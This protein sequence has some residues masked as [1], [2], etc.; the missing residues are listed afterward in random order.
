M[1]KNNIYIKN[2]KAY[3]NFEILDTLSAGIVLQGTEVKSVKKSNLSFNDAYCYFK[4]EE[5]FIKNLHISQYEFG[6]SHDPIRD[7]K[8]LL[9]K[10]ELKKLKTS[11]AEKGYT[12]VPISIFVNE[13]GLVKVNI[14][15]ARGKKKYDKRDAL[16]KRDDEREMARNKS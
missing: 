3:F 7:R 8:L 4:D 1:T 15:L 12:V 9:N 10:K 11:I 14:A 16:K 2:K 13:T 5:L 6:E